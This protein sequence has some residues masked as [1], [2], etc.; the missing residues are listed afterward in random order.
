VEITIKPSLQAGIR[1]VKPSQGL[2]RTVLQPAEPS[3]SRRSD[4]RSR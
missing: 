3:P 2:R 1:V 4:I